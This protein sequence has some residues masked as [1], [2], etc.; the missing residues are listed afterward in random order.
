MC[1][2]STIRLLFAVLLILGSSQLSAD[3]LSDAAPDEKPS[4]F[5]RWVKVYTDVAANHEFRLRDSA[6][7]MLEFN[8]VPVQTYS[9]PP[10]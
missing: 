7:E 10:V 6:E 4:E 9:H 3:D 2:K 1:V 8:P 5:Q